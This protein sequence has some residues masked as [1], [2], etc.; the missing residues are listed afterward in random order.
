M[1][2]LEDKLQHL[3]QHI[4]E[5]YIVSIRLEKDAGWVEVEDPDGNRNH[6][7]LDE[8]CWPMLLDEALKF[9]HDHKGGRA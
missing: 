3:C 2:E 5:D 4:P 8:A 6:I 9:C 1:K 7:H